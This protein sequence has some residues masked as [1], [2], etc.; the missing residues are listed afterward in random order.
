[1]QSRETNPGDGQGRAAENVVRLPRD[2]LGPR[3]ELVPMGA[4]ARAE[5]AEASRDGEAPP[6]T[7]A[8]FWDEDSSALHAPMQAP[9]E[10]WHGSWEPAAPAAGGDS[11]ALRLRFAL[12]R[13]AWPNLVPR[14]RVR[15]LLASAAGCLVALLAVLGQIEGDPSAHSRRTRAVSKPPVS[16]ATRGAKLAQSRAQTHVVTHIPAGRRAHHAATALRRSSH[17]LKRAPRIRVTTVR[18]P[19]H[20]ASAVPATPVVTGSGSPAQPTTVADPP[21]APATYTPTT[22]ASPAP[23]TTPTASAPTG[24]PAAAGSFSDSH[25]RQPSGP[26]GPVSLIGAGTSP[27]G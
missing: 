14:P 1:M 19:H 7:A 13:L 27:S 8:S 26:T 18:H 16:S 3:D 9:A 12:P 24:T 17:R 21:T 23:A 22:P 20:A 11:L 10:E 5:T 4:R 15:V 2:W 25:P 6:P